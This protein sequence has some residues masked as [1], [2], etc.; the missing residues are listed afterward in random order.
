MRLWWRAQIRQ[1]QVKHVLRILKGSSIIPRS[2]QLQLLLR[3]V[4]FLK[5]QG[6]YAKVVWVAADVIRKNILH[7]AKT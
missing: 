5:D 3:V 7:A 1:S 2:R 4:S 6:H